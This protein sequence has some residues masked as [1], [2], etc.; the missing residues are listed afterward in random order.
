MNTYLPYIVSVVC[1]VIAGFSS[2][3]VARKQAKAD[4]Q[5]LE[6]QF[7]LDIEKER[8]KFAMEKEKMEM[9]Y[10]HQ[11]EMQKKDFENT[12]SASIMNKTVDALMNTP[13]I[14]QRLAQSVNS[15]KKKK[16]K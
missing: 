15:G 6:K 4:I 11:L 7:E 13:E 5:R 3:L 1:A 8:E 9:E 2:Y 16:N 12:L 14:R 10:H